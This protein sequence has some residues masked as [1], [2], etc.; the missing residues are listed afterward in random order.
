MRFFV[1]RI[2]SDSE[3]H[4]NMGSEGKSNLSSVGTEKRS[5]EENIDSQ[6]D[7]IPEIEHDN[8]PYSSIDVTRQHFSFGNVSPRLSINNNVSRENVIQ[9][10][11]QSFDSSLMFESQNEMKLN[12]LLNKHHAFSQVRIY[13]KQVSNLDGRKSSEIVCRICLDGEDKD[14]EENP[15]ISP[16]N[17]TGS[18]RH[19]HLN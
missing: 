19:V 1:R 11:R 12:Q 10:L 14:Q 13:K 3:Y 18:M 16:C 6:N 2:S 17:C 9:N 4:S 7:D 15:L 5:V 8:D